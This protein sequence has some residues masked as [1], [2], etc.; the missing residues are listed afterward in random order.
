MTRMTFNPPLILS[1]RH[2]RSLIPHGGIDEAFALNN[3]LDILSS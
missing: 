1:V 3:L 2:A